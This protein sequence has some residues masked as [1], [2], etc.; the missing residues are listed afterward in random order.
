MAGD[1]CGGSQLP[2]TSGELVGGYLGHL[3]AR[4]PGVGVTVRV[5]PAHD[6]LSASG[7]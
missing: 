4:M 5:R 1:Q 3:K 2:A 7:A 6:G